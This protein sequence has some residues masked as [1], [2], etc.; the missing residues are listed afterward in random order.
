MSIQTHISTLTQTQRDTHMSIHTHIST[1]S[2]RQ[3]D[4]HTHTHQRISALTYDNATLE[5]VNRQFRNTK[6]ILNTL[7]TILQT[8]S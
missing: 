7:T 2:H 1:Y 5:T 6:N 4:T 3:T 8:N